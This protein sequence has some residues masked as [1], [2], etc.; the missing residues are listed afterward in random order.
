MKKTD[1]KRIRY[2]DRIKAQRD[3]INLKEDIME[4]GME[5]GKKEKTL[6]IAKKMKDK[7]ILIETIKEITGLNKEEIEK[8]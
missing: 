1:I 3:L 2:E 4:K 6:E 7:G 8:L 5:K